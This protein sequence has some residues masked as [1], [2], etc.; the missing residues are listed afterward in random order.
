MSNILTP[1]N[2]IQTSDGKNCYL[3]S[4]LGVTITG[5]YQDI[6]NVEVG[7]RD[8]KVKLQF[9]SEWYKLSSAILGI[10]MYLDGEEILF[11]RGYGQ[12]PTGS[13]STQDDIIHLILPRG[14]KFRV[15]AKQEA[16][17]SYNSVFGV[18]I[19][20]KYIGKMLREHK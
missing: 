9:T 1:Q 12:S 18:T 8:I 7:L 6:V 17:A 19:T 14:S 10:K 20:G 2:F 15:E 11:S 16:G 3:Y 5:S 4:G 13:T